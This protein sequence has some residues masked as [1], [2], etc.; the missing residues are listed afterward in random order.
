MFMVVFLVTTHAFDTPYFVLGP[1][2]TDIIFDWVANTTTK[3]TLAHIGYATMQILENLSGNWQYF[4]L[5]P[6]YIGQVRDSLGMLFMVYLLT[7]SHSWI[8]WLFN[9]KTDISTVSFALNQEIVD[10]V[11]MLIIIT[12]FYY[13]AKYV[14]VAKQRRA[15]RELTALIRSLRS[16]DNV[17]LEYMAKCISRLA[18]LIKNKD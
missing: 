3:F 11:T 12:Y 16:P 5:L 9:F 15:D 18:H 17:N 8:N 10:I 14:L 7:E 6:L 4:I 13:Y 1:S 2:N